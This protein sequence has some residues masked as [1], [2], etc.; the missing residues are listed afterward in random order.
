[1]GR[2]RLVGCIYTLLLAGALALPAA[3]TA[4]WLPARE[5]RSNAYDV[6]LNWYLYKPDSVDFWI[7]V[8]RR[9]GPHTMKCDANVYGERS[10]GFWCGT[11]SCYE[12]F[13]TYHCWRPVK[14]MLSP[15]WK[16]YRITK[17]V[18]GVICRYGSYTET[19]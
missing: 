11:Y 17:R 14:T 12:T 7:D 15:H 6:A 10:E 13:N 1:V 16:P 8:C 2:G 9:R 5:A 4:D 18:G 19:Y 3:A